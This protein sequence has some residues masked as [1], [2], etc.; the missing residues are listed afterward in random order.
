MKLSLTKICLVAVA[1]AV[2]VPAFAG[3]MPMA[4]KNV[5]PVAPTCDWTGLYIGINAG[6]GQL[7]SNFTDRNSWENYTTQKYTTTAFVG[8]GQLG[9]NYQWQDLV[10]GIEADFSGST[11]DIKRDDLYGEYLVPGENTRNYQEGYTNQAKIDFMGSIRGRLGISLLDNKALLYAT[12]GGAFAHGTWDTYYYYRYN[13]SPPNYY[14]AEWRG[15]D[16]R[17]GWVGGFGFEYAFN[18]HWSL[19]G[20]GLYYW[21]EEDTTGINGPAGQYY[22]DPANGYNNAYKFTFSDSFWTYRI[23]LNYKFTGFFGA[24]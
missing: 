7:D 18:C 8:G 19:R 24:R 17:W 23:G 2:P 1:L 13:Y 4:E 10:F 22:A 11:A 16:W 20:E 14:D 3:P 21:F 15:D 5:T 12:V 6:I 9:Y